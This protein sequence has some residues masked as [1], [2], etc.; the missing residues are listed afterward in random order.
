MGLARYPSRYYQLRSLYVNLSTLLY[1]SL[2]HVKGPRGTAGAV[3]LPPTLDED[4]T[5]HDANSYQKFRSVDDAIASQLRRF[6]K[7]A[8]YKPGLQDSKHDDQ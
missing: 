6:E 4:E 5:T 8:E 2:D 7:Q 3:H 1:S